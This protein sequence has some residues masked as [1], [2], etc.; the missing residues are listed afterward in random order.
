MQKGR[1]I[2]TVRTEHQSLKQPVSINR[3]S[4][5]I[6]V[7]YVHGIV[8]SHKKKNEILPF[9]AMWMNLENIMVSEIN[10]K[11][12][13]IYMWNLKDNTK[14][15]SKTEADSQIQN[16]NQWSPVERGQRG[17]PREG[18]EIRRCLSNKVDLPGG[19]DS[20][21]SAYNAGDPGSIPGLGRS[22]GEGN[23]NPFQYSC[24]ENPIDGRARQ[25]TVHGVAESQT[26][27]SNFT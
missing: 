7:I 22:L 24:L 18:H 3:R 23:G 1:Y 10:Q 12:K 27:L 17:G 25:A 11:D 2:L 19:S 6:H 16:T 26:R 21:A 20:K 9:A 14:V 15:Y 8:V 13:S 4:F 5:C